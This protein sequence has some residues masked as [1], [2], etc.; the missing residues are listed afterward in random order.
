MKEVRDALL[1]AEQ[2]KWDGSYRIDNLLTDGFKTKLRMAFGDKADTLIR[3]LESERD[4]LLSSRTMLASRVKHD[5]HLLKDP[6]VTGRQFLSLILATV[7]LVHNKLGWTMFHFARAAADGDHNWGMSP[8]G[9]AMNREMLRLL[10]LS[11]ED[12]DRELSAVVVA[13]K[14]VSRVHQVFD[15]IRNNKDL[16]AFLKATTG[17]VARSTQAG[18][19]SGVLS[20]S[21]LNAKNAASALAP[22]SDQPDDGPP[23]GL[24]S[25]VA[26][27]MPP[28]ISAAPSDTTDLKT[29]ARSTAIQQGMTPD[30][31]DLF[32]KL[33]QSGEGG[34][35]NPNGVSPKGA[36]GP[37]QLMP[38]T[39][40]KYGVTDI[41]DPHQNIA[42]GAKY[43]AY[44][45]KRYG[46]PALAVAAYNAGEGAVDQYGGI[47]PFPETIA[48]VQRVLG[49]GAAS[50]AATPSRRPSPMQGSPDLSLT[51]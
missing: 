46:D 7:P 25:A 50:M 40:Q 4:L 10:M 29:F 33:I 34:F 2:G 51:F 9:R 14:E 45:L 32:D 49:P 31:A 27:P 6:D 48:Y 1:P 35:A 11:P 20:A 38:E 13:P 36:R 41:N 5:E 37:A 26:A 30:Q 44:L 17:D 15:A 8:T 18:R 12:L 22:S 23:P 19:L 3:Q 39:A 16:M 24:D 43:F 47:P 42:G 28:K 21:Q